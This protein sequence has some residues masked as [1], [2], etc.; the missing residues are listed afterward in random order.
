[1][2]DTLPEPPEP[3][4]IPPLDVP[5]DV[6]VAELPP[7]PKAGMKLACW[8]LIIISIFVLLMVVWIGVSEFRYSQWLQSQHSSIQADDVSAIIREQGTFREFWLKIFQTVLLNTLLPVLTAILGY[9]FGS[10]PSADN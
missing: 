9:T 10:R 4:T 8:L 6:P 5:K 3:E 2:A 7:L 1:M